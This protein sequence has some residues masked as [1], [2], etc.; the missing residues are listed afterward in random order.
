MF[1]L[2]YSRKCFI[3]VLLNL[4]VFISLGEHHGD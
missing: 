3:I 1:Y 2:K 4:N